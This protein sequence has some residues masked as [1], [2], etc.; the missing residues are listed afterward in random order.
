MKREYFTKKFRVFDEVIFSKSVETDM[1]TGH[2]R[3]DLKWPKLE[4]TKKIL[5]KGYLHGEGYR[6][7][8]CDL[9]YEKDVPIKMRDGITLYADIFRPVDESKKYPVVLAWTPYGKLDPPNN[10]D[11][12]AD[13]AHMKKKLECGLATFEGPEPDYWVKNEFIVAVVDSRGST[14]SEGALLYGGNEEGYDVYDTVEW[15]GTQEWSNGKVGMVGN[16]W[17]AFSQYYGAQHKPPHLAAIAPWEGWS[18]TYRDVVCRGGIP[19]AEFMEALTTTFRVKEGVEDLYA[20]LTKYPFMNDYWGKEKRV[21][22]EN[23]DIPMYMVASWSSNVHPYGTFR[24]WNMIPSKEKWLRVHNTQEWPDQQTPKYRD[25]LRDFFNYYL[26]GIKNDW[27]KTP[28]VRVSLLDPMG[29]D[30]VDRPEED[31]PIPRTEYKKLYLN[32]K[33]LSLS[34]DPINEESKATY[35]VGKDKDG[36]IQF[37]ITFNE[38]VE[39][40]GYFKAHLFVSTDEGNDMDLFMYVNKEDSIG[41]PNYPVVLGVDFMGAESRLRVSHRKVVKGELYDWCH[42]HKEEE[43]IKPNEI[44]EIETVF[45]P[46]GMVWRKGETLVLTISAKELQLFEFPTSRIK[47]RNKGNHTIYTGGKYDSYIEI[48]VV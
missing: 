47:T 28:K 41:V 2:F 32:G 9:I 24:A 33:D 13:R 12:Y 4:T 1:D 46:L 21:Q 7:I 36:Q 26:K 48:P 34:F 27:P 10:Y 19:A 15:L 25:E 3:P 35:A 38:D 11:L 14:H 37:R 20:M 29:P 22:F 17:L 40:C 42:E 31:F 16:S 8:C 5:S 18:D 6:P 45:W 23:I 39:L 44:V 30:I 43:L